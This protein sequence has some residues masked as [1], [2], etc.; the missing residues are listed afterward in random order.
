M[1]RRRD[2][3]VAMTESKN[4]VPEG[5]RD[6]GVTGLQHWVCFGGPEMWSDRLRLATLVIRERYC[7]RGAELFSTLCHRCTPVDT[8]ET[9]KRWRDERVQFAVLQE[10]VYRDT[11]L[12][13]S[14]AHEIQEAWKKRLPCPIIPTPDF[15]HVLDYAFILAVISPENFPPA[16][17]E[18]GAA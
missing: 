14:W 15:R 9:I 8:L 5:L 4:I 17:L 16:L 1:Q 13:K 3:E 11:E 10:Q 18:G 2:L 7:D 12:A 6:M